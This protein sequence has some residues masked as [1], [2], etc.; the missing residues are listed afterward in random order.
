MQELPK[1]SKGQ[2]RKEKQE[3]I[4]KKVAQIKEVG[5]YCSTKERNFEYNLKQKDESK[6]NDIIFVVSKFK[7]LK[8]EQAFIPILEKLSKKYALSLYDTAVMMLASFNAMQD[9]FDA[10]TSINMQ[11]HFTPYI[12]PLKYIQPPQISREISNRWE[13]FTAAIRR[14]NTEDYF[15]EM[16]FLKIIGY[17]VLKYFHEINRLKKIGIRKKVA[18]N[19]KIIINLFKNRHS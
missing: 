1:K 17:N 2:I 13:S 9:P 14:E 3:L 6:K 12:V 11:E 18:S 15:Y 4:N 10:L 16:K 7:F 19:S 8:Q 5:L